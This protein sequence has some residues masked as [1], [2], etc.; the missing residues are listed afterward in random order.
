MDACPW[1]VDTM[2]GTIVVGIDGSDAAALAARWAAR[3]AEMRGSDLHLI[4]AW[5]VRIDGVS[6]AGVAWS[7]DIFSSLRRTAED[8]L[9]AAADEVRALA[10]VE[11]STDAIEGNAASVLLEAARDADLLVV[12]SRGL[13][14]FRDLLLGSVSQ[15][16]A[17][18]ARC[19]VV[20]VRHLQGDG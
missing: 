20:I 9:E 1:E 5:S 4:S 6:F 13:G 7:D 10:D 19:P 17:N 15:R 8:R 14:G 3:E 12:G 16:C 2:S 18:H 11:V